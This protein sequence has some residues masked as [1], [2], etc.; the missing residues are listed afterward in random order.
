[1]KNFFKTY[2]TFNNNKNSNTIKSVHSDIFNIAA[3]SL[4]EDHGDIIF[5]KSHTGKIIYKKLSKQKLQVRK[6][7]CTHKHPSK[8]QLWYSKY[9]KKNSHYVLSRKKILECGTGQAPVPQSSQL[10]FRRKNN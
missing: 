9:K 3:M 5:I 10:F 6:K 4:L 8:K 2:N 7:N 1:M